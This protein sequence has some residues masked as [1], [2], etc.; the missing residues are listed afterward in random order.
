L[1][2]RRRRRIDEAA[3]SH[4]KDSPTF[5]YELNYKSGVSI[6]QARVAATGR[7]PVMLEL[8]WDYATF[9]I[10]KAAGFEVPD[11]G[12]EWQYRK[13]NSECRP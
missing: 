11:Y 8:L 2:G 3:I 1:L 9:R 4:A 12:K 13:E 6:A 10:R 5:L 7:F